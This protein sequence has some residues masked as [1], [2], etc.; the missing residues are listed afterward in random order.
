LANTTLGSSPGLSAPANAAIPTAEIYTLADILANCV[1]SVATAGQ[2]STLFGLALPP[3]GGV[4]A[5]DT[6]SAMLNI[7]TNPSGVPGIFSQMPSSGAPFQPALLQAPSDWTLSV[8]L[9]GNN[10]STPYGVA[11]DTSGNAWV[12]NETGT[13][14]SEFS[15]AG[16]ALTG[17]GSSYTLSGA[18][19]L[20]IDPAGHI[21]VANTGGNNLVEFNPSGTLARSVTNTFLSAPVDI[22]ADARNNIWVANFLINQAGG[23][24][25]L[26]EFTG[27]GVFQNALTGGGSVSSTT[28]LAVDPSGNVWAA[29]TTGV[30]TEYSKTFVQVSPNAGYT[31]NALQGPAGIAFDPSGNAW[32]SGRGGPELSGFTSA[33]ASAGSAPIYNV[34]NQPAGV[35]VDSAGTIWVTNSTTT[36]SLSQ[37]QA[38]TGTSLAASLGS[39]NTPVEIAVDPSGNLW[40]ANSGDNSVTIF[41]GLAAPTTTPLVARTQ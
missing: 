9:T 38:S 5:T 24:F 36:G 28:A 29:N 15:P 31:D 3:S 22:A 34:L 8:K 11:I 10:L 4:T 23:A 6:I 12:T 30:L 35:A 17:T 40:T 21:W 13:S 26:S 7:A 2:C 16:A 20:S 33:G 27:T 41:V 37:F 14:V 39:L 19:G 25:Y 18:Q 1:N 32:V